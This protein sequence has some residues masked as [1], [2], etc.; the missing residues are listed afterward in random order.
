M[1]SEIESTIVFHPS[2]APWRI[3]YLDKR[4]LAIFKAGLKY[5]NELGGFPSEGS[6]PLTPFQIACMAYAGTPPF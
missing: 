5:F 2:A 1:V 6:Q 4:A 3:N